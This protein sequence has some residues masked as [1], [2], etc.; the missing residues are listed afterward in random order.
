MADYQPPCEYHDDKDDKRKRNQALPTEIHEL[1][2][3]ESGQSAADE[4]REKY[5]RIDFQDNPEGGEERLRVDQM[6]SLN[7]EGIIE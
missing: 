1:V 6:Q 3:T 4:N 5:Q 2:D 7:Q